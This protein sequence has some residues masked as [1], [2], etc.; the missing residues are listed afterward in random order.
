MLNT[1]DTIVALATAPGRGPIAVIRLSGLQTF[2]LCRYLMPDGDLPP[3]GQM[4]LRRIVDPDAGRV[5]DEALFVRFLPPHTYTGECLAEFHVHGSPVI[6]QR[7]LT[8]LVKGGAR[9]ARPG[10]FTLRSFINGKKDLTQA[11]AVSDLVDA[12]SLS[13]A[14]LA[15]DNLTGGML[16]QLEQLEGR[17]L[18][19]LVSLE[20]ALDFPEEVDEIPWPRVQQQLTQIRDQLQAL[21]EGAIRTRSARRGFRVVLSGPPNV[22]KSSLFNALLGRDRSIVT[23]EEG[24]TRDYIE[25]MLPHD[26]LP[27]VLVDTAGIRDSAEGAEGAGVARSLAQMKRASL[28]LELSPLQRPDLQ[29]EAARD[30]AP[31]AQGQAAGKASRTWTVKTKTDLV[32]PTRGALANAMAPR[33][34]LVSS[35]SLDGV[36]ALR[37]AIIEKARGEIELAAGEMALAGPRQERHVA[38]ALRSI[39]EAIDTEGNL[40]GDL[41]AGLLREALQEVRH[42]MGK[43]GVTEEIL[44]GIFSTFCIGK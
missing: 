31:K 7:I 24:T 35:A 41:L 32:Q 30:T 40:P 37:D 17:L 21:V 33:T 43:G 25:E 11:E 38:A 23:P 42:V 2:G 44:D 13:A 28:V 10:E 20:G 15:V 8:L 22:G 14:F 16:G 36:D 19:L 39:A 18:E 4:A 12:N 9:P 6:V 1:S 3:H 26:S 34:Y 5:L 27:I 29:G